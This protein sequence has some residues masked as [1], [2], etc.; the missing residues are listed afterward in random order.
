MIPVWIGY[1]CRESGAYAVFCQSIINR[2]TTPVSFHPLSEQMLNFDG[3]QDGSNAFIY[4]R[5][6]IPSLMNYKGWAIFADGDMVCRRDISELW[7]LRDD[8]YAAQVV[9]QH[10]VPKTSTKY[11]GSPME[12]PNVHYPMKNFSSVVLWNCEHPA[13]A[14]LT[15]E[16]VATAG[17]KYLHRFEWLK[18]EELGE[19]PG[20]WNHLVGESPPRHDAAI[21]HFTLGVPG[22][23]YYQDCEY[24]AEW[25]STFLDAM[26]VYGESPSDLVGRALLNC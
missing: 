9:K 14:A 6:L 2:A 3:Q 20:E 1:D 13:N 16:V 5:Y 24:A 22:F 7:A 17:G 23:A 10:Y 21:A 4:S 8:R 19:L 26:H 18:P 12:S 25:N 11:R 15:K